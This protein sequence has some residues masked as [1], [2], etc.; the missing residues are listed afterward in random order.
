[1]T[2][3]SSP[4][5]AF[6][7]GATGLLGNNLARALVARGWTVR[8]L[9]RNPDKARR[10]FGDLPD[11]KMVVGDMTDVAGFAPALAGADVVF[12]TAAFFRDNYK[13]GRHWDELKRVN[14]EGT[15]AL[16]EAAY[17]AGVRRFVHTSSV[18]VLDGAPGALIDGTKERDPA[19]ADDYYRSKILS[20]RAVFGFLDKHPDM[21]VVL[22]LPGWMWGPGDIG[23][24]SSGQLA[25]DVVRGALP[26]VPPGAFSLVDARDVAEAE[27][28]AADRGARGERYLAAGRHMTMRETIRLIGRVTG[29]AVPTRSMP[30]SLLMAYAATQEAWA[31]LSGRQILVSLANAR[32]L[33]READRS[34]YD[35]E[36]SERVLGVTFRPAET[37]IADT[38]AWYRSAGWLPAAA[39]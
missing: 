4:R 27:I 18:A 32:L 12:H 1:M 2:Q 15:A 26:A 25:L 35:S 31:R 33:V 39:A 30:S 8:A 38:I 29:A 19:D 36:K 16:L 34:R 17:A 6:V 5:V 7:T 37:T 20:D 24:T 21:H 10:Q 13:G 14:V 9:A 28:A 22:V 23:P 3:L 11:L